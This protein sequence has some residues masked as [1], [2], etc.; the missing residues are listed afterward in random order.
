MQRYLLRPRK[1]TGILA[2]LRCKQGFR[3]R[4]A[5]DRHLVQY[6]E[7]DWC[8]LAEEVGLETST[9]G[10]SRLPQFLPR[11]GHPNGTAGPKLLSEA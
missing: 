10:V 11:S 9:S 1:R 4:E 6:P 7:G 2:C 8:H 3:G 5:Y